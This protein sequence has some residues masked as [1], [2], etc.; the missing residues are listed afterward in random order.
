[1]RSSLTN[2]PV[3][4]MKK[5]YLFVYLIAHGARHGWSRLRWLHDIDHLQ[6]QSLDWALIRQLCHRFEAAHLA[7]QAL[8]LSEQYLLT[9]FSKRNCY[10]LRST[11]AKMLAEERLFYIVSII[12]LFADVVPKEV[13]RYHKK[14]L[15]FLMSCKQK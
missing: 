4:T 15:Y 12:L 6:E 14:S 3:Y 13:S 1:K 7:G 9:T 10:L 5:E 2:Y 8:I 11:R